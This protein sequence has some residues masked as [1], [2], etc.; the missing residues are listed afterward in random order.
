MYHLAQICFEF[1]NRFVLDDSDLGIKGG[2][3]AVGK[4]KF[5]SESAAS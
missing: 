2:E 4:M 3:I 1:L 5:E